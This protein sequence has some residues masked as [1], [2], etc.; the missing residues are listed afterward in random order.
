MVTPVSIVVLTYN[1]PAEI[2]RSLRKLDQLRHPN[3]EFIIVDNASEQDVAPIVNSFE[4]ATLI[5]LPTNRGVSGRNAGID[6]ATGAVII[7]LDDDVF[8]VGDEE[9]EWLTARFQDEPGLAA[10]NFRVVDDVTEVQIDWVHHRRLSEYADR[11]FP[12][13]EI[14]EGAVAFRASALANTSLYPE[15][16]FISHEGPALAIQ[17]MNRGY[18]LIYSPCVTVRHDHAE[19]GRPS[20][21]R[22]YYDTRNQI[23]LARRHYPVGLACNKLVTGLGAMLIYAIRDGFTVYWFRAVRDGIRG[24]RREGN[25]REVMT[26]YTSEL[27]RSIERTHP[28]LWYQA[29]L[30]VFRKEEII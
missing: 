20:W 15:E 1:R 21:R 22:Y 2:E 8:G 25:K 9:I 16:F 12:T 17:I 18:Y 28:N 24:V 3:L 14:T 30:R 26:P 11:E 7:T 5:Q 10:I 23:W 13:Y 4:R 19:A 6:V 27:Y 29:Y